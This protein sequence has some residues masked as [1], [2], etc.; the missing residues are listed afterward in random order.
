MSLATSCPS[1]GT[2]FRVVEDQL[3][4]SEGWVRCGHC[5][6]VF[7]AL[8]GL[9]DLERRD[10]AMQSLRTVPSS[11]DDS[12]DAALTEVEADAETFPDVEERVGSIAPPPSA[13]LPD[14]S[15]LKSTSATLSS[16]S[17]AP[18][19][20]P[21]MDHWP[22]LPEASPGPSTVG[23][24]STTTTTAT[25]A[26][27]AATDF[28]PIVTS[29]DEELARAEAEAAA[30]HVQEAPRIT[31]ALSAATVDDDDDLED[32][33]FPATALSDQLD[34]HFDE[35][36]DEADVIEVTASPTPADEPLPASEASDH[37]P[38]EDMPTFVREAQRRDWWS[39]PAVQ[40]ALGFGLLASGLGFGAQLAWHDR[41][42]LAVACSVCQ[43]PLSAAADWLGQPLRP[44]VDLD[45]VEVDNATLTQPPGTDGYRLTVQVRNHA[46]HEVAAP[47]ME[48]SLTDAAG[49]LVIR[50]SFAPSDF[51]HAQALSGQEESTWVLEFQTPQR[52]VSGYTVA[53]FYP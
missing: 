38:T 42:R 49:V 4:V 32:D 19:Q 51:N 12:S 36:P 22:T 26:A 8:E 18:A 34:D 1:C 5:H 10:S 50:R 23:T 21:S 41:D 16:G 9:F 24:A 52:K 47:H 25:P 14:L 53:A 33:L 3:K 39:R 11:L 45:V 20:A 6:D 31:A 30:I 48:L 40:V 7:N 43:R 13:F 46:S 29:L 17:P 28:P 15:E 35:L 2:V 37:R 44:P 27:A